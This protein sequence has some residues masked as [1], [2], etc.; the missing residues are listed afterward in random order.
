MPSAFDFACTIEICRAGLTWFSRGITPRYSF[1]GASGIST[2][3]S[4][5]NGRR[6]GGSSGRKKFRA[7]TNA[8]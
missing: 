2:G 4:C 7:T 1:T 8:T 3:A 5:S 6:R